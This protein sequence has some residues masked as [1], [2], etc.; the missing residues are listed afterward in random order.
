MAKV[1]VNEAITN[2]EQRR[3][4][5]SVNY[6]SFR[7]DLA[8]KQVFFLAAVRLLCGE[9]KKAPLDSWLTFFFYWKNFNHTSAEVK[10]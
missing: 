10:T 6:N 2:D 4:V 8:K 3:S 9:K 1:Q 5:T 7:C